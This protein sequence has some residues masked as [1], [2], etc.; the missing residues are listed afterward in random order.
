[1]KSVE[2]KGKLEGGLVILEIDLIYLNEDET[3]PLECA[4]EFPIEKDTV[5]GKL[6]AK[7]GDSEVETKIKETAKA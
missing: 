1:M 4:Y 3:H 5:I 2:I 6:V 7:I